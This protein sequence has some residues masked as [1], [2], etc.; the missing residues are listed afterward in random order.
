M[1]ENLLLEVEQ[2]LIFGQVRGVDLGGDYSSSDC[3][4]TVTIQ[5]G[6]SNPLFS[7]Y[8]WFCGNS[9]VLHKR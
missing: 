3:D 6:V 2:H 7:E 1:N 5:D 8:A 4:T 9:M